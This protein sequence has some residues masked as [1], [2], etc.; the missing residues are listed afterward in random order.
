MSLGIDGITYAIALFSAFCLGF[1]KAGFPG[2]AMVNVMIMAEL[3]GAKESVGIILPLLIVCDVTVYPLFRQYA[4]WKQ[5]WPLFLPA[6]VGIVVGYLLLGRIDNQTARPVIGG[7]V[8]VMLVLQLVRVYKTEFLKN[9]PDSKGFFWGSGLTI[10]VSTMMANAAGPVFS[11]YSLVHRMA[12]SDFLGIGARTFLVLN[13]VKVP[14]MTD[15]DIINKESLMLDAALLPSVFIGIFAGY[16][17]IAKIPQ[18]VFEVLLYLFSLV[19]GVRLLF[20]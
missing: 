9:M 16:R 1:S 3:F 12:K 19:A 20:F 17:L 7:I 11:I 4:S 14:F 13:L 6:F 5:T 10:G 2:L 8:L 15:L 18:K